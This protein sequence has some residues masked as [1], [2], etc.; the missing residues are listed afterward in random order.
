MMDYGEENGRLLAQ[1]VCR[2]CGQKPSI[3]KRSCDVVV[4]ILCSECAGGTKGKPTG[5]RGLVYSSR[6]TPGE[7]PPAKIR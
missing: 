2:Y 5:R 7:I 6:H 4:D 3:V 1:S